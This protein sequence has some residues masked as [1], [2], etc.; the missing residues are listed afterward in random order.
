MPGEQRPSYDELAALVVSQAATIAML[1]GEVERLTKRV[2]ELERQ[3]NITSRNSS[4][5]PSRDVYTKPA[6]KSLRRKTGRGQGKQPGTPGTN[7][8]LI[9]NPTTVVDHRPA[10]CDGCGAG[11]AHRRTVDT[12][13][14]QVHDLP[15]I[16]PVITEHRM[17]ARRCRCGVLTTAAAPPEATAPA[18]YGPNTT[19]LAA[20]LLTYQHLPIS[21]TAELLAEVTGM[22]VSTGWV[23]GV[24]GRVAPALAPFVDATHTALRAEP[25]VNFDETGV[26]V[27]G[28]RW[29]LHSASTARLTTYLLHPK[30]G[31]AAIEDF[32]I[33]PGYGGVAV[34]DG[35]HPYRTYDVT[36]ALCNAHHQRE[37]V[38]A[39]EANPAETWPAALQGVLD[40]L[41]AAAHTARD[42]DLTE[43][44]AEVLTA[45]VER[46]DIHLATGLRV[47]A[48]NT[49]GHPKG[50][51]PAQTKTRALLERL[52]KHRGDVLRFAFDLTVP[53]TN[54]QAERDLRMTKAQLKIT[55]G[56]RTTHGAIAWLTVR[57]YVSTVRK[58]GVHVLT[59]LRDAITGNPWLPTNPATT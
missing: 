53:F 38:A 19:A 52:H 42:L 48:H 47:H 1:R 50:G 4:T 30:R 55:G 39:G 29:W 35:W 31:R 36:H 12:I 2:V 54:N 9:D 18:C 43:I 33:L 59:A 51:R 16:T 13:R 46:Y 26:H 21:R 3:L 25:V 34:H 6:P 41:N 58:N 10:A 22:A 57:S 37:L 56:W 20:Y 23:A 45:M 44:P 5:P 24:L 40:E 27:T 7:L 8:A 14:R 15:T 11:L 49:I 28:A 17:H 32:A